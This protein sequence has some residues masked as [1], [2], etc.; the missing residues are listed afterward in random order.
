MSSRRV[1]LRAYVVLTVIYSL[2]VLLFCLSIA[3]HLQALRLLVPVLLERK[4]F[5][6][7]CL[8][9]CYGLLSCLFKKHASVCTY[10]EMLGGDPVSYTHLTLPTI[11]SV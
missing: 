6:T 9:C 2:I 1:L 3:V 7:F 11:C 4:V 8:W 10:R 5:L